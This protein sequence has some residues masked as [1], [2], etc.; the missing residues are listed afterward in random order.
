MLRNEADD[1]LRSKTGDYPIR[2]VTKRSDRGLC[3][4]IDTAVKATME[5]EGL[6]DFKE[7]YT[8]P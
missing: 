8:R 3:H 4:D 6:Y 1:A 5:H 7:P 2:W